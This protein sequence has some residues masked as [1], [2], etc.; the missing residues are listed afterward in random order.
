MGKLRVVQGGT[1][2]VGRHAIAGML[3]HPDMELAGVFVRRPEN[4]GRDAG[5]LA[6]LAP[7]GVRTTG[8]IEE[9]LSLEADCV[10]HAGRAQ[11]D[12]GPVVDEICSILRSSKNVVSITASPLIYPKSIGGD[13]AAKLEEACQAGNSSFH[14]TGIEPGWASEVVP[15]TLSGILHRVDCLTVQE[16]MDYTSY[17]N[18]E[19]LF[20]FMGFGR[21]PSAERERAKAASVLPAFRAPL[22]MVTDALGAQVDDFVFHFETALTDQTFTIPAGEI[23]QGTV[24]AMRFGLSAIVGG[25]AAMV[26][27]HITR[28]GTGQAPNW[29]QGRGWRCHVEGKPSFRLEADI[30]VNPG[31][32]D[33]D[34][35]CQATAM[36]GVNAIP[37]VCAAPAGIRTFLDLPIISG[38]G[39]FNR[40]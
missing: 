19:M 12:I 37:P 38:R 13:V 5:E 29:P 22:M 34:Q 16:I 25:R 3:S 27:E 39:A 8:S 6:G 14:G 36:H 24:S 17:D 31:E 28:V 35:A 1:G 30:A 7:C 33:N 18:A 15:L 11:R 32:D 23:A 2:I 26:V 21:A 10:F 4:A 40:S 20:D 9:I